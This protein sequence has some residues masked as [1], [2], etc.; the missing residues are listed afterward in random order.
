MVELVSPY[1]HIE[2]GEGKIEFGDATFQAN[3]DAPVL[4]ALF[5]GNEGQGL[6]V[7]RDRNEAAK[8]GETLAMI[9]FANLESLSALERAV[10][11]VRA[12]ME[13]AG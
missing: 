4:H 10:A 8:E 9:T 11:R 2:C 7:E 3:D 5:I 13:A 1:L 12:N 6:G